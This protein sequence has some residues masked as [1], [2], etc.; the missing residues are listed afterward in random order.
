MAFLHDEGELLVLD[1]AFSGRDVD[2][3]LFDNT[4]DAIAEGDSYAAIGTE[5]DGDDYAVQSV[6]GP[7]VTQ[8][9]GTTSVEMG[10]LSYNVSDATTS[11]N[12]V[13]VRDSTSGD[14]IFTNALDQSYDLGSIDTLDLS[15]VGMELD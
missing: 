5:P 3:G 1:N 11:V 13:Y 8:D 12:Y 7:T 9:A 14:L 10:A 6:T 15:N 4:T 2:V